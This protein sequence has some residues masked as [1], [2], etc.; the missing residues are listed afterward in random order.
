M[1]IRKEPETSEDFRKPCKLL[2]AHNVVFAHLMDSTGD[3]YLA[4]LYMMK[5]TDPDSANKAFEPKRANNKD[6]EKRVAFYR[7]ATTELDM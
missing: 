6:I 1:L 5:I 3:S 7:F 4:G 2:R